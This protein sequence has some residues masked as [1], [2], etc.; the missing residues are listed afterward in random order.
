MEHDPEAPAPRTT[1]AVHP[2][3]TP[4]RRT[5][6]LARDGPPT[7]RTPRGESK[8]AD[9]QR[10]SQRRSSETGLGMPGPRRRRSSGASIDE[11]RRSSRLEEDV[12]RLSEAFGDF[13]GLA[14]PFNPKEKPT[15]E[16]D[17]NE[18]VDR[19]LRDNLSDP[20]AV[21]AMAQIWQQEQFDH[22][23]EREQVRK[24][25]DLV[26]NVLPLLLAEHVKV[27]RSATIWDIVM[28]T[29]TVLLT[30]G[31]TVS[32]VFALYVLLQAEPPSEYAVPMLIMLIIANLV[33]AGCTHIVQKQGAFATVRSIPSY[34]L[35]P[36]PAGA[37]ARSQPAVHSARLRG[38][39]LGG[40]GRWSS[41][42]DGIA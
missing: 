26:R 28:T 36:A 41:L 40:A 6:T 10:T 27:K 15:L 39:A 33:Q 1:A 23:S 8:V 25:R 22:L 9:Q 19:L 16:R 3:I 14:V 4:A 42:F 32:D 11:R 21:L 30:W 20:A 2:G 24:Y 5:S 34:F 17:F 38:C 35:G 29:K 12:R 7:P 13:G 31:D 37:S 18:L